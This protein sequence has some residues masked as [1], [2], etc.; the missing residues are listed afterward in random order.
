MKNN[1]ATIIKKIEGKNLILIRYHAG[2][3]KH[4]NPLTA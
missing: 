1:V 3:Q 2:L 4:V